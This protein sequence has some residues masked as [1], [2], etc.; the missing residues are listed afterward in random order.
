MHTIMC[1]GMT[2]SVDNVDNKQEELKKSLMKVNFKL[3]HKWSFNIFTVI[4]EL[5]IGFKFA[6][7]VEV[8]CIYWTWMHWH[9]KLCVQLLAGI[10]DEIPWQFYKNS[11]R[12]IK[13]H[14]WCS[15]LEF[16]FSYSRFRFINDTFCF[17]YFSLQ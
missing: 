14:K 12:K 13:S 2:C 4:M 17:S 8:N 5:I 3:L 16:S 7:I 15:K 11:N 1:D 9:F 10:A 6:L